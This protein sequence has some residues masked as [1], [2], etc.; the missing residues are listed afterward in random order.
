MKLS[1]TFFAL[2]ALAMLLAAPAL[3][4]CAPAQVSAN[5]QLDAIHAIRKQ[6][7]LP[8]LAL[9]F[10]EKTG[11]INSPAGNLEVAVYQD[12]AGRKYS[13]DPVNNQVVEIDARVILS[14]HGPDAP[15]LA[16][17]QLKARALKYIKA[18]IPDFDTL[19]S[20]W[21]YEE[22]TKGDNY[23]YTWSRPIAPGAMNRPF[24]QLALYKTGEVF[25]YYN[26]LLLDK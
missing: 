22:G 15:G 19:Q 9:T 5:P 4:G 11:M 25:A 23:F 24:A 7:E 1:N 3:A 12:S 14:G 6:L 18:A 8:D 26:T 16:A 20:S 13:V 2:L 17:D 21:Q 10:V